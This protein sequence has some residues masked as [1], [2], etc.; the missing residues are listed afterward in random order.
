MS[1]ELNALR[2]AELNWTLHLDGIWDENRPDVAELQDEARRILR[3]RLDRIVGTTR[4]SS[5]LGQI[6]IG[7]AGSGKTHLLGTLRREAMDRGC[8]FLSVD[9]SNVADFWDTVLLGIF[10]SI[11]KRG[12][13]A[14][15]QFV[16]ALETIVRR[17]AP[18][19]PTIEELAELRPPALSNQIAVIQ[20]AL[21]NEHWMEAMEHRDV[22]KALILLNSTDFGLRNIG[23]GWLQSLGVDEQAGFKHDFD[24]LSP[25]AQHIVKGLM[26]LLSL[27]SPI[28]LT[29]DQLDNI[30]RE[31]HLASEA[32]NI[33]SD[34]AD[35]QR[36]S[37]SIIE[38]IAGGLMSMYD[39]C[40]RTLVVIACLENTWLALERRSAVPVEARFE[41]PVTLRP[42]NDQTLAASLLESRLRPA[43]ASAD[44]EPPY[45]TWP[46]RREALQ[47]SVGLYPR[48][49]LRKCGEHVE[50]CLI[51]GQVREL[52]SFG[53]D[54]A[55]PGPKVA[56]DQDLSD[57]FERLRAQFDPQSILD[58][59]SEGEQDRLIEAFCDTLAAEI[60]LPPEKDVEVVKTFTTHRSYDPLHAQLRVIHHD[61]DEHEHS[62][63]L[64]FLQSTH[65]VA[66]QA[67]L[68]AAMTESGID[69]ALDFRRLVLFRTGEP[70]G[71]EVTRG[72]IETFE[73]RG[74]V[75]LH[76]SNEDLATLWALSKLWEEEDDVPKLK[77]WVR[78]K[79]ITQNMQLLRSSIRWLYAD[80][81]GA[82]VQHS[83]PDLQRSAAA[84]GNEIPEAGAE[85]T[86]S[87]DVGGSASDDSRGQPVAWETTTTPSPRTSGP[88]SDATADETVEL[89]DSLALGRVYAGSGPD[90][91]VSIPL[92]H[93]VNHTV[94]LAGSGSGKTV[95]LKRL[96]EEAALRGVPSIVIDGANDLA[97]LGDPWPDPP[98]AH[99]ANDRHKSERYFQHTDVVVFTPG[100]ESGRP[101]QFQPIPALTDLKDAPDEYAI[102]K[103]LTRAS[104]VDMLKVT[105]QSATTKTALLDR[106]LDL[107]AARGE[108]DL[109][110]LL[111]VFADPP[112]TL[113]EGY[114][115]S[116][117]YA[118]ELE[119]ELRARIQMDRLLGGAGE[120]LRPEVLLGVG[121]PKTRI[122]VLNFIGIP[123]LDQQRSF[124]DQLAR[125]LFVWIKKNPSPSGSIRGLLVVDEAKDF[126]PSTKNVPCKESF[127]RLAAQARKYGLGLVFATQEPRSIDHTI[128][129]NSKTV[130]FGKVNSPAAIQ[131]AQQQLR[132]RGGQASD[133]ARLGT[134]VFYAYSE[135]L[136]APQKI[137]TALCLSHHPSTSLTEDGV[138]ARARPAGT[139]TSGP[140]AG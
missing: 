71:G 57:R 7:T 29:F 51:E 46:I 10:K 123:D 118:K 131:T 3:Y 12:E 33:S 28:V 1:R 126:V 30:V 116:E 18:A 69:R 2:R 109:T 75:W 83:E 73:K 111:S 102:A 45:P 95:F 90:S 77:A 85:A 21:A 78:S 22:L 34:L 31:H 124:L 37:L 6:L 74:G 128:L 84:A 5:P 88:V 68:K 130:L 25:S 134:G 54:T 135:A 107:L 65:A 103:E 61:R 94:V 105:G 52:T 100:R 104:L 108:A 62:L 50:S 53:E 129:S 79:A 20:Q 125:I 15:P 81:E 86:E 8:L 76:P 96:I 56:V 133:I 36:I 66:F 101:L 106:A 89:D 11:L 80:V 23:Y 35:R 27:N 38:G 114:D 113:L 59:Q 17:A 82:F 9:M 19:G 39:L 32:T 98:A 16:E 55:G 115:K 91:H 97:R 60:S 42:L 121:E 138:L 63:G 120:A 4:T 24:R 139:A 41:K 137:Q 48:E 136:S 47:K 14:R 70:P 72:L 58:V 127:R 43:Y 93:L 99:D 117:K 87:I 67:R 44:F 64:R 26:W 49:I 140:S 132:D 122:S 112:S 13:S 119:A 40:K 92:Q 110:S